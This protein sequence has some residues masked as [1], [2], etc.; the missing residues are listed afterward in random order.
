MVVRSWGLRCEPVPARLRPLLRQSRLM[1]LTV[2]Q[3]AWSYRFAPDKTCLFATQVSLQ[4]LPD[5]PITPA[6][7]AH[8]AAL[9]EDAWVLLAA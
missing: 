5:P 9:Q 7:N 4:T 3:G 2:S 8:H 6:N 1:L